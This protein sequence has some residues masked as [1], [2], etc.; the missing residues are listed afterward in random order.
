MESAEQFP[1]RQH[2]FWKSDRLVVQDPFIGTHV[3]YPPSPFF[4]LPLPKSQNH[5]ASVSSVTLHR[6]TQCAKMAQKWVVRGHPLW[7]M[8]GQHLRSS[9]IPSAFRQP[10]S[11]TD[12]RTEGNRQILKKSHAAETMGS[13]ASAANHTRVS[14]PHLRDSISNPG[15]WGGLIGIQR[16]TEERTRV[17]S[18]NLQLLENK[19]TQAKSNKGEQVAGNTNG[20]P[21]PKPVRPLGVS[22]F[23][24]GVH[25]SAAPSLPDDKTVEETT[26][27]PQ[28]VV[29]LPFKSVRP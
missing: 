20:S 22:Q 9:S 19:R 24:R 27:K 4:Q 1:R 29:C 25:T 12:A 21:R 14:P 16:Q 26:C 2:K 3:R 8:F 28:H 7:A 5:A 18:E 10:R 23:S 13:S 15:P 11:V 17:E 6:I